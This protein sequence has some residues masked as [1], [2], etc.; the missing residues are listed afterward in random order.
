MATIDVLLLSKHDN[1]PR[2]G[3]EEVTA[4]VY[5]G[6]KYSLGVL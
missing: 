3:R 5:A 6:Y 2:C 1:V 4:T